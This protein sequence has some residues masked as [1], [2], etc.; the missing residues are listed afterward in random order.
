MKPR[1]NKERRKIN[2]QGGRKEI[3]AQDKENSKKLMHKISRKRKGI[4][5]QTAKKEAGSHVTRD[6]MDSL[7]IQ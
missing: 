5:E 6:A 2:R 7:C 3:N 4:T 1:I